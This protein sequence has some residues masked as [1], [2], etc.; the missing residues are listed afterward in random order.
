MPVCMRGRINIARELPELDVSTERA[1]DKSPRRFCGD[2]A[3]TDD[4]PIRQEWWSIAAESPADYFSGYYSR[5][6]DGSVSAL[7]V[8]SPFM[9]GFFVSNA[10]PIQNGFP[11]AMDRVRSLSF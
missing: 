9:R 10:I 4:I 5:T 6:E 7:H 1:S 11:A 3:R 8:D 2:V